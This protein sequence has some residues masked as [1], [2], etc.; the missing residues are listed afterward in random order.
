MQVYGREVGKVS[1]RHISVKILD[2][3]KKWKRTIENLWNADELKE[4]QEDLLRLQTASNGHVM[5]N[6]W[7]FF[8]RTGLL[9]ANRMY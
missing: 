7:Y 8:L 5:V 6:L 3:V 2:L 4:V 1:S 9:D